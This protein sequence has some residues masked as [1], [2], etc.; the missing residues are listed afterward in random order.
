MILLLHSSLILNSLKNHFTNHSIHH[1]PSP[2]PRHCGGSGEGGRYSEAGAPGHPGGHEGQDWGR[3]DTTSQLTLKLLMSILW[4][5]YIVVHFYKV[6]IKIWNSTSQSCN[7]IDS[8]E[9]L[10]SNEVYWS[11]A[12]QNVKHRSTT[13]FHLILHHSQLQHTGIA[14]WTSR[15]TMGP[16]RKC[17]TYVTFGQ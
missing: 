9:A 4:Q 8:I 13:T 12:V 1:S 11:C 3:A 7:N 14:Y 2:L 5:W 10:Y 16:H 15:Y 6:T 17:R